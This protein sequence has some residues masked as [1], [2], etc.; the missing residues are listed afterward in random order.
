MANSINQEFTKES[1]TLITVEKSGPALKQ[2]YGVTKV[3]PEP[4]IK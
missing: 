3:A 1:L 2:G 4:T